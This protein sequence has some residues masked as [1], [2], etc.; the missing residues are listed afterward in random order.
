MHSGGM[1]SVEGLGEWKYKTQDVQAITEAGAFVD[2]L[3]K[4][5]KEVEGDLS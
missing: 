4:Q 5:E 2:D 1:L 3:E